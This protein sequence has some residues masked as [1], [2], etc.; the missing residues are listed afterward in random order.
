MP[1][2]NTDSFLQLYSL[3]SVHPLCTLVVCD[4]PKD[5]LRQRQRGASD[6]FYF[7]TVAHVARPAL[8]TTFA[9]DSACHRL[10]LGRWALADLALAEDVA[11]TAAPARP[12][13]PNKI[14]FAEPLVGS[15]IPPQ[16][17]RLEPQILRISKLLRRYPLE[18][19]QKMR[20]M[21]QLDYTRV[22]LYCS[23]ARDLADTVPQPLSQQ[24]PQLCLDFYLSPTRCS[25]ERCAFSHD[26]EIPIE[27]VDALRYEVSRTPCPLRA[28][29]FSC[30]GRACHFAHAPPPTP[31]APVYNQQHAS[32]A[33]P[34]HHAP[35]QARSS[36]GQPGPTPADLVAAAAAAPSSTR[37]ALVKLL[38][39]PQKA[40]LTSPAPATS[41]AR[42]EIAP[43]SPFA[44]PLSLADHHSDAQDFDAVKLTDAELESM[45]AKAKLE[46]A[47][48][49]KG[50]QED[51]FWEGG[52]GQAEGVRGAAAGEVRRA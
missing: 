22:R 51:P 44:H 19:L 27:V 7:E 29:G 36:A 33:S 41:P 45:L 9:R 40:T 31:A 18:N 46:E 30:D 23:L 52:A 6:S 50:L 48:Y 39:S 5:Q 25:E 3:D 49:A 20:P 17:R 14:V 12:A 28:G 42:H 15:R 43:N 11:F 38:S 4:L 13:Y 26:Y 35:T 37:S 2:L 32:S 16:I 8:A 21:L 24:S 34:L 10:L 47:E 1:Q